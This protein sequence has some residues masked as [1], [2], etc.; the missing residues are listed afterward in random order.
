[1]LEKGRPI[2][3]LLESRFCLGV[4][5]KDFFLFKISCLDV[6]KPATVSLKVDFVPFVKIKIYFFFSLE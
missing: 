4:R 6:A 2:L 1:M 3:R 5:L